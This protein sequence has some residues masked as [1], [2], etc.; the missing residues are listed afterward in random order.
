MNSLNMQFCLRAVIMP[1]ALL[2]ALAGQ[3]EE[4][5]VLIGQQPEVAAHLKPVGN[6]AAS[7]RMDLAIG[8]PLRNRQ[9]LNNLLQEIYDPASP[10]YHHYLTSEQFTEQFGPTEQDYQ[11]VVDYVARKG[12]T[13]TGKHP[14]RLLLDVTGSAGDIEK[15][16]QVR[17]RIYQHPVEARTFFAPDVDPSVEAGLPALNIDGLNNYVTPHPMSLKHNA[18]HPANGATPAAGSGPGGTYAGNDFRAAYAPGVTLDGTGQSV[19]LFELEGYYASDIT[20]Y[21][22]FAGVPNV[23]LT[24]VLIDGYNGNPDTNVDYV[25]EVSLDIEMAIS[26][27]PHLSNVMVY[28]TSSVNLTYAEIDDV[29]N[30]MATDNK[31]KQLSSSWF[32]GG[33]TNEVVDKIFLQYAMQG[34]SFFEASGDSG[35]YRG[36]IGEPCDDPYITVVG[37]TTLTTSGPGGS[38]VSE[39]AW[40]WFPGQDAATSGGFS[41]LFPIPTWQQGISMTANEGSTSMRNIPDVALT[42]DNIFVIYNDGFSGE[43]GGTSCAAPLWAGFTAMVNQHGAAHSQPTVGFIN[44]AVYAIGKGSSYTTDFRDT[45]NG[46]NTNF[47]RPNKYLAVAGYDLC[48]GWGTP[49]GKYL[50]N[51]LVPGFS[52]INPTLTWTNPSAIV[53][54]AA[55][56]TIQLNAKASV[57]GTFA[58]NPAAGVVL[59]AGTNTLSVIFTPNDTFDYNNVT[60]R[61]TQVVTPAKLS[62]TANNATRVYGQSN[63]TFTANYSGFVNGDNASVLTG[64]PSLTTSAT[65]AST[66]AG[67]PYPIVA[68]KGSLSAANY[69][70]IFINGQLTITPANSAN[71]VASSANPSPTGASVKFTATLTAVSPGNGTPTG[72]VQFFADSVALGTPISLVGGVASLSTSSLSQ[73]MHAI[74]DQYLGDGNFFGSTGNLSPEENI[75]PPPVAGTVS[76]Q[77][78]QNGGVKVRVSTVLANDSDPE[79]ENLTLI[80]AGPTSTNGGS[81]VVNNNWIFY[82]P[83]PGFTKTDAFSYVIADSGGAQ[84]TGLVLIT[85]PV[86]LS[87]SQN[88]VSIVSLGNNA[89]L[90][91]FQGIAGRTYTI[92]YSQSLQTPV[93]QTL[94][95]STAGATGAFEFT[96]TPAAGSPARF[97]RSTYP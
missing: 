78:N 57:P 46:N 40:S 34:Q 9:G 69:T 73:G 74:S 11:K 13:V 22:S 27:A 15:A 97:Y 54:G 90:I 18:I 95:T 77:R 48:T 39:K 8:L 37:G 19:G 83:L 94:G 67:G 88:I 20:S 23:T 3:A 50:I 33:G 44:P 86:D 92:Q 36:T 5:Q 29:L 79:N 71:A 76:L 68:A 10:N 81:V 14:N 70:F 4:K 52:P 72:T 84:A 42:A 45:T 35:A 85:V 28:E 63:P 12:L 62:V 32:W 60:T 87:Q 2:L 59:N 61:V 30:R 38:W 55:L 16:F 56:S 64:S 41:T 75:N 82:T 91:S 66:V 6:V 25:A 1:A 65:A 24:N 58:Y 93:W 47:T 51:A 17:M 21:E 89:S 31:A 96:D 49:K 80:S 43:F 7:M 26:M 53:Y